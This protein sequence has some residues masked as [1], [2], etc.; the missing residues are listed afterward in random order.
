MSHTTLS[1]TTWHTHTTLWHTNC[2]KQLCHTQLDTHTQLCH[3]HTH[4]HTR[5]RA[6]AALGDIC[7]R[8][9]WQAW[10]LATSTFVSRG[11]QAWH[12]WD[13]AG[14]GGALGRRGAA[15]LLRGRRGT[16]RHLPSFHV[17]LGDICLRFMWQAWHLATSTFVSRGRSGTYGTGS[18][19]ALGCRGAAALLLLRGRC[20]S[21][22][23][24]PSFHVAGV[25]LGDICLRFTWQAWH[26]ATSTFVSRGRRGTWRHLPSFHV[27]LAT[28]TFLSR[29]R[30]G[31]YGTGLALVACL[32]AVAPRHFCVAGAALGDI[33]LRFTWQVW[34]LATSTFVSRGRRGAWRHP[35]SFHV[36]A[37]ALDD[38]EFRFAWQR[39]TW[40]HPPSFCVAR[41][42]FLAHTHTPCHTHTHLSHTHNFVTHTHI[43]HT[44][45]HNFVT[46]YLSHTTLTFTHISLSHTHNF[47]TPTSM[48]HTHNFVTHHLSHTTL[49]HITLSH[50]IFHTQLCH[51]PSLTH[52]FVTHHLSH[53]TLS[54]TIFLTQH[55]HTPSSTHTH[56]SLSHTI[57]HTHLCYTPSCTHILVTQLHT[58][59]A[60][61]PRTHTHNFSTRNIVTHHLSYTTLV[62]TTLHIQPFNSSIIHHPP[63]LSCL[64]RP[65]ATLCSD[66]WNKLTCGAIRSFNLCFCD[67][68]WDVCLLWTWCRGRI[69]GSL[70][71]RQAWMWI[72]WKRLGKLFSA[73]S[74]GEPMG[75]IYY[76]I[77]N[78]YESKLNLWA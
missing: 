5:A 42:H 48:S 43:F 11:M 66:Y 75:T 44:H 40:R 58:I 38:I 9:T 17:A 74:V 76:W 68:F 7:L 51:T 30:R 32:G 13:W 23:H 18:S 67:I 53:T 63:C 20:G 59:F 33:H 77:I 49:S 45:T 21:W 27:A 62:H 52:I 60:T 46:H 2:H 35:F 47:V 55:C 73:V 50:T 56:T 71:R 28:S 70:N 37:V 41:S 24:L 65:A 36:A 64:P 1:H 78:W 31:T 69:L 72:W 19:G 57:F 54:H 8:F 14:S 4:T 61:H 10:H 12:L 3:T 34:H 25:A 39:G 15:A 6:R 26:L 22:R 29:G 16:W